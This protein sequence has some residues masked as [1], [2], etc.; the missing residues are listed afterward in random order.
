MTT[1]LEEGDALLGIVSDDCHGVGGGYEEVSAQDHV[2][3]DG[4]ENT[5]MKIAGVLVDRSS[6]LLQHPRVK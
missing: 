3:R 5:D 2:P 4:A 6:P 1:D